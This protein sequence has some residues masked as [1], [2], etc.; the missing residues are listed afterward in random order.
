MPIP[1]V[2]VTLWIIFALLTSFYLAIGA[3]TAALAVGAE[4]WPVV[5]GR[6]VSSYVGEGCGRGTGPRPEGHYKYSYED[7]SY[8]S[9]QIAIDTRFCGFFGS[10]TSIVNQYSQGQVVPVY[11]NPSK[12]HQS[13]LLAGSVQPITVRNFALA[14]VVLAFSA[15]RLVVAWRNRSP[16]LSHPSSAA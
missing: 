1:R 2:N 9:D 14:A 13:T 11:V 7:R 5:Q 4:D 16:K 3:F 12:P 6:V 8:T 10:D 15:Y